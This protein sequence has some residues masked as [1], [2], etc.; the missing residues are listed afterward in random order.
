M[1]ICEIIAT[2]DKIKNEIILIIHWKGGRHSELRIHKNRTGHHGRSNS[3]E[4]VEIIAQM[5]T[6]FSDK[7]IASTL[8]RLGLKTGTG[9]SWNQ[10]RV[11]SVKN[12]QSIR[13]YNT[14]MKHINVTLTLRD[15]AKELGVSQ[16]TIRR[17]I[18]YKIIT[19]Q[20][21]VNCAPWQ[22]EKSELE[23]ES[24]QKVIKAIQNGKKIPW[25]LSTN[26]ENLMLFSL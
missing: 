12:Y 26:K 2:V 4:A 14:N 23:K 5:A 7:I 22:I 21:I 16:S 15:T 25:S 13:T 1:L 17:L 9:N 11:R 24:V 3:M 10:S 20:Q 19:A 18:K 8:N 6:K